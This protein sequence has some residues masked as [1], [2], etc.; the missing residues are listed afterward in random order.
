MNKFYICIL[1]VILTLSSCSV[2]K[3]L[4]DG[5]QL[6]TGIK[7]I[8]F[9]GEKENAGGETGQKAIEE[10]TYALDCAPNG[11]IFGSSALKFFPMSVWWH[12]RYKDSKSKFGKWMFDTFA[13]NPVLIST[14]KPE[15]RADV[16]SEILKYYGYFNG[17]VESEVI[18]NKKNPKKAAVS[19]KVTFGKPCYID[20]IEYRG[21]H[22]VSDSLVKATTAERLIHSGEQFNAAAMEEER[23]RLN[24]L[25]RNNGYYYYQPGYINYLADTINKP[26]KASVR[27]QPV[28][29]LAP[30]VSKQW[31]IGN[32]SMRITEGNMTGMGNRTKADTITRRKFSYIYYG[33]KLPVRIGALMRNMQIRGGELY[34]QQKQ[35]NTLQR[36]SQMGIFNGV[37]FNIKEREGT[38]TLDM[39]IS[40]Q[41]EKPYDLT[42]ELNATS[43]SNDQ[44]GPGTKIS[45]ARRNV[46]RGGETLKLTLKGSYEW[47]T[48]KN[49][50][51][52]SA[53]IN[54]WEMGAD[55]SLTFPRLFFPIIHRRHLRVPSST[56]MRLFINQ[57][58][59]SGFFKM[60]R[61]GGEI[62]YK[63]YTKNTTTHT[64]TPFRL[65]YDMLQ[66][67]TAKFDSIA[68]GNRSIANSFRNQFIPAM[69]Y[70]FLYDN[71]NTRHRNKTWFEASVTSAGNVTSLVFSAFGQKFGEKNKNIL[72][73]PYAQFIKGTAELRQLWKINNSHHIATRIMIGA[74]HSYGNSEYAPYSEQFYV[75][76]ANSLRA[77]TVRSVGPG[78]YKPD[79]NDRYSYL[80]ET[81]TLKFEMNA[82][83]RFRL[84][85]DLHGELFV[86]AGNVW[87]MK[88][89]EDRPGGEFEFSTFPKQLALNTGFGFRYDLEFLVLRVDFGLGLHAPYKTG[90]SGYFNLNPFGDG[91][92]WHFAIGYPF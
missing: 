85:S 18:T 59:R 63:V 10:V 75:G 12:Y 44:I 1:A 67:T 25:F 20:S 2:T 51:G 31:Y 86:D 73:N 77:F 45:I 24:T 29:N 27:V 91:F 71:A 76:G 57:M 8:E 28:K 19:Y 74:I 37:S 88:K 62:T 5:E 87:L 46:F 30:Q 13:K 89:E 82:E 92:A 54:S 58:N 15:L 23:N 3:H 16:A 4:P 61:S 66:R 41:L 50:K 49:V 36:L 22:G 43:K 9:I 52:R 39:N 72:G 70:T 34:S 84:I 79:E 11:S 47:Q 56:S 83:Y 69:Q 38:D 53:L 42:F 78:S 64:I 21:F 65:A 26:G 55:L 14:V 80:D 33:K 32:V 35:Q 60:V 90:K 68:A 6:Y 48:D 7:E 40:A 81:G 17:K